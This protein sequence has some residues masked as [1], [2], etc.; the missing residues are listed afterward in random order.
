M[1]KLLQQRKPVQDM[2]REEQDALALEDI[3]ERWVELNARLLEI[4]MKR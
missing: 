4:L 2:T 3:R 1:S